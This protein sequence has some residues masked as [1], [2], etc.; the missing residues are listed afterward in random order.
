VGDG[1][2]DSFIPIVSS[3]SFAGAAPHAVSAAADT[4][5]S[6]A[7][8]DDLF[9]ADAKLQALAEDSDRL[10][11]ARRRFET[12]PP[13]YKSRPSAEVTQLHTPGP[14]TE[15]ERRVHH[16]KE[17][18]FYVQDHRN[19]SRPCHQF[20]L[21]KSIESDFLTDK[22]REKLGPH[23]Y[24]SHNDLKIAERLV[25]ERWAEWGIWSQEWEGEP[26]DLWKTDAVVSNDIDFYE[27]FVLETEA[28]RETVDQRSSQR[29]ESQAAADPAQGPVGTAQ[30]CDDDN[31]RPYNLFLLLV[32]VERQR[33]RD[34]STIKPDPHDINT[35][36]YNAVRKEWEK[37]GI[38]RTPW[39]TLP[40]MTWKHEH[41]LRDIIDEEASLT[42]EELDHR[43]YYTTTERLAALP[44]DTDDTDP[45]TPYSVRSMSP[46]RPPRDAGSPPYQPKFNLFAGLQ[47]S[48]G[49]GHFHPGKRPLPDADALFPIRGESHQSAEPETPDADGVPM[50]VSQQPCEMTGANNPFKGLFGKPV[51]SSGPVENSNGTDPDSAPCPPS[52]ETANGKS[53]PT[54]KP[55]TARKS[56][57]R[58]R[59]AKPSLDQ[60]SAH[61]IPLPSESQG[62]TRR[63]KR[64]AAKETTASPDPKPARRGKRKVR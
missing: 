7:A 47:S 23:C 41:P 12:T 55:S 62:R 8:L 45:G 54:D 31:S 42:L 34:R 57:K 4:T 11:N 27:D 21:Q 52:I 64:L 38:W 48:G 50:Q 20:E 26:T 44:D 25:R 18:F 56:P 43:K 29:S 16:E 32:G 1:C 61:A 46:V 13:V 22:W 53:S 24:G 3:S 17:R 35:Q 33:L 37:E 63:S 58:K 39:G 49:S 10:E 59:G 5:G 6:M 60:A 36:A 28:Q 51:T 14:L 2:S 30:H 19:R 15:E 40:G 9:A